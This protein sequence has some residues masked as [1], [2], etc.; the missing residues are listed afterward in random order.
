MATAKLIDAGFDFIRITTEGSRA[1][2]RLLDYYRSVRQN[3]SVAGKTEQVGGMFGFMGHKTRHAFFGEKGDWAMLQ[4]TGYEAKAAMGLDHPDMQATRV[5]LQLTYWVGED[6]VERTLRN[7]YDQACAHKSPKSRP[8]QVTLIEKR[9]RAQTV[10][11]GSRSSDIFFRIY[12]KFEESGKEEYRGSVRF[13]LE[14]K[15]RMAKQCWRAVV[16]H[17]VN[18]RQLLE[19][20]IAMLAERGVTVPD[21]S[22]DNQDII[23]LRPVP[24]SLQ[25]TVGWLGRQVAPTVAKLV[26]EWGFF[27]AFNALFSGALTEYDKTVILNSISIC[28][29]S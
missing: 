13:E 25:N 11:I 27:T 8:P 22:L 26:S 3:D 7:A 28:W 1:R 16:D 2:G 5:D 29:G 12:D 10:Y 15:G 19:M 6:E 14:L 4:A 9:H 18:L 17:R 24:S 20:V 23:H 21:D